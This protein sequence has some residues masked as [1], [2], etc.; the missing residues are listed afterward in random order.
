MKDFNHVTG[1]L[2]SNG[3]LVRIMDAQYKTLFP[4]SMQYL[5]T[6]N[7]K[8][9]D[10]M[11]KT[12]RR[13]FFGHDHMNETT[14]IQIMTVS[15]NKIFILKYRRYLHQNLGYTGVVSK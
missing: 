8:Y 4:V 10:E 15:S 7:L 14:A 3:D 2:S 1:L 11:S 12:I 5:W 6:S 9:E 13:H